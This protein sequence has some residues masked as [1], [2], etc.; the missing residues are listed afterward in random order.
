MKGV[1]KITVVVREKPEDGKV[2]DKQQ[3][4][5]CPKY[6]REA[7]KGCEGESLSHKQ[8]TEN[9]GDE[10]RPGEQ[11]AEEEAEEEAEGGEKKQQ[12]IPEKAEQKQDKEPGNIEIRKQPL[13]QTTN[14]GFRT[15][16]AWSRHPS[17]WKHSFHR[18]SLV[19]DVKKFSE[20]SFD[21]VEWINKSF[22][23][24]SSVNSKESQAAS[25]VYQLQ[26]FI[27]EINS[28]LE[29]T[30][31]QVIHNLPLVLKQTE[32][33]EDEVLLLRDQLQ[34][35]QSRVKKQTDEDQQH[36]ETL[37]RIRQLNIILDRM[38]ICKSKDTASDVSPVH[39]PHLLHLHQQEGE[40]SGAATDTDS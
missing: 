22:E 40:T 11:E 24:A 29:Q 14:P 26:L 31:H 17:P 39:Q 8:H 35:I 12:R 25:F 13:Q 7:S 10:G 16:R 3:S 36:Q 21:P 19:M 33:L 32:S 6:E 38:K 37:E 9:G 20:E 34:E 18:R 15:T 2:L 4:I 1:K 27:Q 5:L 30:A 28:S 23:S